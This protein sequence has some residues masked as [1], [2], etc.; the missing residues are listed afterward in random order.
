MGVPN[1]SYDQK[2]RQVWKEMTREDN[3]QSVAKSKKTNTSG[4]EKCKKL[5]CICSVLFEESSSTQET[6]CTIL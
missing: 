4:C 3:A 6:K 5:N 2:K 1:E